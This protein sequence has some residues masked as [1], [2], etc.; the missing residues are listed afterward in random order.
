MTGL[1]YTQSRGMLLCSE[2]EC[3]RLIG[4]QRMILNEK[5]WAPQVAY[6]R[7]PFRLHSW[8]DK[9]TRLENRWMVT[10]VWTGM[11]V[12]RKW[13]H[14]YKGS[15]SWQ[16]HS[17]AELYWSMLVY[18]WYCS[19]MSPSEATGQRIHGASSIIPLYNFGYLRV[20]LQLSHN[21]EFPF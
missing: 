9:I 7:L 18:H 19:K 6:C 4:L 14:L 3:S 8:N 1:W 10:S 17:V 21:S 12:G 11:C 15:T 2:N 5:A 20:S 16:R 13:L